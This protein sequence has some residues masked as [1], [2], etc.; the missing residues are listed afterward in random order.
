MYWGSSG[1]TSVSPKLT[2]LG[3]LQ[4]RADENGELGL[5][6]GPVTS[7]SIVLYVAKQ[8][9]LKLGPSV[10]NVCSGRI[11]DSELYAPDLNSQCWSSW[12]APHRPQHG[13]HPGYDTYWGRGGTNKSSH[14]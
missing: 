1:N 8:I 2:K 6:T 3:D 13:S 4:V 10:G 11:K 14:A 5:R 7:Y 12:L 9:V